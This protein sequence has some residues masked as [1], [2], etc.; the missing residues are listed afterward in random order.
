MAWA[1][2]ETY[3]L[4]FTFLDLD[5]TA[6]GAA[7]NHISDR[8]SAVDS[9]LESPVRATVL[10]TAFLALYGLLYLASTNAFN[11]IT[12]SAVLRLVSVLYKEREP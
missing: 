5:F 12:T 2:L 7:W 9:K 11:S 10:S 3:V 1:L 8:F 4:Y 6:S